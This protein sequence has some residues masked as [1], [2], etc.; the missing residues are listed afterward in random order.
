MLVLCLDYDSR[1][2]SLNWLVFASYNQTMHSCQ[3]VSPRKT[4]KFV[5]K[6]KPQ[7][8]RR[9]VDKPSIC[10]APM[11]NM[12]RSVSCSAY[13]QSTRRSP[14]RSR[15][16]T[17]GFSVC[18]SK[19]VCVFA[20]KPAPLMSSKPAPDPFRQEAI[21]FINDE[22]FLQTNSPRKRRYR[23][24]PKSSHGFREQSS[25]SKRGMQTEEARKSRPT[26]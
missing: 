25:P 15:D 18:S 22:V 7:S 3:P 6:I 4:N 12:D 2:L 5:L 9:S 14:K 19:T 26:F 8:A 17:E 16:Y 10:P 1:K 13:R 23:L 21:N 11:D 24:C 20:R